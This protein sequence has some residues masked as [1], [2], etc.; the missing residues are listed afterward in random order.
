LSNRWEKA[1]LQATGSLECYPESYTHIKIGKNNTPQIYPH[2]PHNRPLFSLK[3]VHKKVMRK[4]AENKSYQQ[5]LCTLS[6]TLWIKL[7]PSQFRQ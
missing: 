4:A 6:T 2:Y 1:I 3:I 7:F 5:M